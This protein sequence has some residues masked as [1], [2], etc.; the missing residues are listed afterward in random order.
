[1]K[2]RLAIL[3]KSEG[4]TSSK[5]AEMLEVQPSSISHL[6]AG[7]NK[8]GFDFLAKVMQ[9]FPA[10]SPDWL[11]L[12][13]GPMYRSSMDASHIPSYR[14]ESQ[15]GLFDSEKLESANFP[16]QMNQDEYRHSET[17]QPLTGQAVPTQNPL[18]KI[19]KIIVFYGDH[20]FSEYNP[21]N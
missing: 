13:E 1:M 17:E 9:Y 18:D 5:L 3:L 20:T 2:E 7:R 15:P 10:I 21:R 16:A 12:G 8:P 19:L 4:L 14:E 11:I 6:L